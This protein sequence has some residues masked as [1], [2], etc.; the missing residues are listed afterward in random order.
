MPRAIRAE[1]AG[2][3]HRVLPAGFLSVDT[4]SSIVGGLA[5]AIAIG[6][7]VGQASVSFSSNSD[8]L[9]RR[10]IAIGGLFG[11]GLMIGLI[12]LSAKSL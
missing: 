5:A 9:R 6:A 12:L 7:F 4:L 11:M 1:L 3:I 10:R 2:S 8:R